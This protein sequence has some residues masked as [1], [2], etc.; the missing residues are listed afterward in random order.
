[1]ALT[2]EQSIKEFNRFLAWALDW[3][4]KTCKNCAYSGWES[5][6][7]IITCGILY[8]NFSAISGCGQWTAKDD[9]EL[10]E[11][12]RKKKVELDSKIKGR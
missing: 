9:P 7:E 11:R 1:M 3:K 5:G 12:W 6:D 10:L 8:Q 4:S 2:D